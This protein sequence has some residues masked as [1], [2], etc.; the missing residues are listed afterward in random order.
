MKKLFIILSLV[1]FSCSNDA[2]IIQ[3][4]NNTQTAVGSVTFNFNNVTTTYN[5]YNKLDFGAIPQPDYNKPSL[6]WSQPNVN[7]ITLF[8]ILGNNENPYK[9][10]LTKT[11][12][13][14]NVSYEISIVFKNSTTIFCTNEIIN[15]EKIDNNRVRGTF[16]SNEINGS[17][18]QI[19]NSN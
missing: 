18:E 3:Q 15:I 12:S 16:T 14:N 9:V 6:Y 7:Q 5:N 8:F 17:F 13:P 2:P 19:V 4:S 1:L 11:T 10:Y